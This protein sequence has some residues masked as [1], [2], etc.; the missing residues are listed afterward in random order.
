VL[1][2]A[3]SPR[4][5]AG[6][7]SR[8]ALLVVEHVSKRYPGTLALDD[9]CL[10]VAAGSVHA[11]VGENG[12]GKS[13]L[14]DI[15][16]GMVRQTAGSLF[17][18]QELLDGLG[19]KARLQ[20][21]IAVVSQSLRLVPH[22]D[23]AHNLLLTNR[24]LRGGIA[25]REVYSLCAE[26]LSK[27][28]MEEI[29][30]GVMPLELGADQQQLMVIIRALEAQPRLLLL[31]EPTSNLSQEQVA[32]LFG[33]L[34]DLQR[35]GLTIVFVSHRLA[36][37]RA[38]SDRVTVL[39]DG[40][41]TG[42]G[43][44]ADF[45]DRDIVRLMVGRDLETFFPERQAMPRNEVVLEVRGLSARYL[46]E[47]VDCVDLEVKR[48]EVVGI[49]GVQGNG[50]ECL[51]RAL[52][53]LAPVLSGTVRVAGRLLRPG[54]ARDARRKGL[55][56]VPKNR[57]EGL[58]LPLSVRQNLVIG[59]TKALS[60]WGFLAPRRE[61]EFVARTMR[62]LNIRSSGAEQ[63]VG[64]LSGGNQQKVVLGRALGRGASVLLLDDPTQGVDVPTKAELYEVVARLAAD[65]VAVVLFSTDAREVV[66]LCDRA[67][68]LSRGRVVEVLTRERLSEEN[69]VAGAAFAKAAEKKDSLPAPVEEK[70]YRQ[71]F[72]VSVRA[73]APAARPKW[74]GGYMGSSVLPVLGLLAVLGAVTELLNSSFLGSTNLYTLLQS[75]APLLCVAVGQTAVLLVGGIDL[76]V[77]PLMSVV[78]VVSSYLLVGRLGAYWPAIVVV[79]GLGA[80]VGL[81]NGLLIEWVGLPDLV[82][83][84]GTYTA[85]EGVALL[86][87]AQPGGTVATSFANALGTRVL[88]IPST[89]LGAAVVAGIGWALLFRTRAGVE[90]RAVG[91]S[92]AAARVTGV[93]VVRYRV[94]CYL[95]CGLLAAVGGLLLTAIIQSGDPASGNSYTLPS[96]TAP[97][98]GGVSLFGAIGSPLGTVI[99]SII[100]GSLGNLLTLQGLS[101]YW[102][103]IATGVLTALAVA[104]YSYSGLL[105][106]CWSE[107]VGCLSRAMVVARG[108]IGSGSRG[109]K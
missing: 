53:G 89:F 38:L 18:S 36:E 72:D 50:Q 43:D 81:L 101:E 4:A 100:V 59:N 102:Q 71:S 76:A 82:A 69:L 1:S 67:V 14:V 45:T 24:K 86:V 77:G 107:V 61:R 40:K 88:F 39:R 47:G 58:F 95:L 25:A 92:R 60:I 17:F 79:L 103:Q 84:L 78:T 90:L 96:I 26:T 19:P 22:L 13:T 66:G 109:V 52:A 42:S 41:V 33:L 10:E 94:A 55:L 6:A 74:G 34:K 91:S 8:E 54:S 57:R 80:S 87:R 65:G 85:L 30:P 16:A 23:V 98:V 15:V 62:D 46:N 3:V 63:P 28:G 37:V 31:D 29:D 49:A 21:G 97:V 75:V 93:P 70:G 73:R 99:G 56:F 108:F 44:M 48:G 5:A 9:V 35:Q 7:G 106:V 2:R 27:Y 12:A 104:S 20:R 105:R 68:L 51:M 83:T 32:W 64:L 11:V